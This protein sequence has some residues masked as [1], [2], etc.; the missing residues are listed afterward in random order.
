[1]LLLLIPEWLYEWLDKYFNY[2][3]LEVWKFLD[4]AIFLIVGIFVVRKPIKNALLARGETIKKQLL[5]AQQKR[6]E[7]AE[8]LAEVEALLARL[9]DDVETVRRQAKEEAELERQR[10]AE[11][12]ELEMKRLK[13]QADREWELA[14]KLARRELQQFLANRSIEFARQ[15][16]ISQLRS[17]D[18]LRL[19]RDRVD[20]LR[21]AGG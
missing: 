19:I 7:A 10:Q 18:D 20:E 12:A 3:G 2:P 1:M 8:Q 13:A 11:A 21:R 14:Q 4:L 9:P 17:E 6:D 5:E 16:V 15:S